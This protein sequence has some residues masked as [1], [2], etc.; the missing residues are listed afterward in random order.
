MA[1]PT[2]FWRC[3]MSN[4]RIWCPNKCSQ[5][6]HEIKKLD[7]WQCQMSGQAR[8]NFTFWLWAAYRHSDRK[9]SFNQHWVVEKLGLPKAMFCSV[10][11]YFQPCLWGKPLRNSRAWPGLNGFLTHREDAP[12]ASLLLGCHAKVRNCEATKAYFDGY[13]VEPGAR[14]QQVHNSL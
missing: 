11:G 10:W 5:I 1:T 3:Q 12:D 9:L 6:R 2:D 13:W 4:V 7:I 14:T 8:R